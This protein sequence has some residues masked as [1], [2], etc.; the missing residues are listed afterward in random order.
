MNMGGSIRTRNRTTLTT[1]VAL[2]VLAAAALTG[3]SI[4]GNAAERW[5]SRS[6]I[7]ESSDISMTGCSAMC[8]PEV[9]GTIRDSASA[10]QIRRLG[11]AATDYLSTHGGDEVGMTL[12]FGKVSFEIGGTQDETS[13]LVD[14]ALT[15]F[16]DDR[17][18]YA[19]VD[20]SFTTLRGPKADVSTL[21]DE[22]A[23]AKDRPLTVRADG[24]D[25]DEDTFFIIEEGPEQCD[26]SEPLIAQFDTFLRDPGV[27]SLWLRPCTKLEV[28]VAEESGV[29]AMVEDVQ[30]LA[31]DPRY[32]AMEFSVETEDGSPYSVTAD[33][34]QLDPL[35]ALFDATAGVASYSVTD[36]VIQV[37][38]SDPALFRS[39]VATIDAE[40][41][42]GFIEEIRVGH[43]WASV[44]LNGDGTADAQITTAEAMFAS[45]AT[46][47]EDDS[48]SF[49]PQSDGTLEFGPVNYD[50]EAGRQIVDAVIAGGLWKTSS[51]QIEVFDQ[52]VVFTVTAAAGSDRFEET[53]S[54]ET[55]ETI[56]VL[57]A[58]NTYWATQ[59]GSG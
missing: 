11:E 55:P 58:L 14:L 5:L 26:I 29:D 37:G 56:Q 52:P 54:N 7:I 48:I 50:E 33:T 16:D 12:D 6:Q 46:R 9:E 18:L 25:D 51:T 44:Y 4:Q 41:R 17:V 24:D 30:L 20:S 40:P 22:Y 38:V 13:Q 53:R 59:T 1:L 47:A 36:N 32:A 2:A 8:E 23:G 39:I 45:N 28:A 19:Y 42:P 34:P 21:F 10:A 35:F 49:S 3:C 57:K 15:A 27:T 43:A 31:S